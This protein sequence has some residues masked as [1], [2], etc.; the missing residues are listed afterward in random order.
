MKC[1][2]FTQVFKYALFSDTPIYLVWAKQLYCILIMRML[3]SLCMFLK[4][5]KTQQ[6]YMI[7]K[8]LAGKY[9]IRY[10]GNLCPS[11]SVEWLFLVVAEAS[12]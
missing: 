7:F 12:W 8:M 6:V 2:V 5:A 3:F 9:C 4:S 1:Q 10:I 11:C